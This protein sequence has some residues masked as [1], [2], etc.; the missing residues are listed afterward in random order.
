MSPSV[1]VTPSGLAAALRRR[2]FRLLL[3]AVAGLPL[4]GTEVVWPLAALALG[5][6]PRGLDFPVYMEA[7]RNLTRGQDPYASF[8][9]SNLSDPTVNHGYIYPPLLAWVLQPLHDL[10]VHAAAW[11]AA[12]VEELFLLATVILIR[13]LLAWKGW[14]SA[15]WFYLALLV[16][17]PVQI[18][19]A[20]IQIG[21]LLLFLVTL[22]LWLAPRPAA[23]LFLAASFVLKLLTAPLLGYLALRRRWPELAVALAAVAV[24]LTVA[25]P[26]WLPTYLVQVLPRIGSGTG[27][28]LNLAP[29]GT[30]IRFFDP[31]SLLGQTG[32]V[33]FAARGLTWALDVL[34]IL[35][36]AW[37]LNW[38]KPKSK[39]DVYLE[40]AAVM[41]LTPLIS[42]VTWPHHVVLLILPIAILLT[43][44]VRRHDVRLLGMVAGAVLLLG[45][46][47][48]LLVALPASWVAR[49]WLLWPL[50]ESGTLGLL[51]LYAATLTAIS[52]RREQL[53]AGAR[54]TASAAFGD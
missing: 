12:G 27:Y 32:P 3:L 52:R 9:A 15:A 40:V 28:F 49:P 33:P 29:S 25:T 38:R 47:S 53:P 35:L 24:L 45:P 10:S 2:H 14:E 19:L 11:L 1:L 20:E 31:G 41:A 22:W 50:M 36:T 8:L 26:R 34:L 39:E 17:F 18:N 43:E 46:V 48:E 7:A 37:R 54:L 6:L 51:L 30:L 13:R 23:G 44:G 4:V 5:H 42:A 16:W 21:D